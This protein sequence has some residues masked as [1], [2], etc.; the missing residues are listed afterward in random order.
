MVYDAEQ[1]KV[2]G[3]ILTDNLNKSLALNSEYKIGIDV[4]DKTIEHDTKLIGTLEESGK[5]K[6]QLNENK[7]KQNANLTRQLNREQKSGKMKAICGFIGG[8]VVYYVQD[9]L[10]KKTGH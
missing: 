9:K 5:V 3:P 7:D 6:D 10:R 2:N 4:R 8:L 1:W